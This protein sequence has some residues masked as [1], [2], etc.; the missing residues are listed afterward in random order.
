MNE[1]ISPPLATLNYSEVSNVRLR[2]AEASQIARVA[3]TAFRA[4]LTRGAIFAASVLQRMHGNPVPIEWDP[5]LEDFD[6]ELAERDHEET[7][8]LRAIYK[9][10]TRRR[11]LRQQRH[12]G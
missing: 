9:E 10:I 2:I 6:P 8:K 12:I 5:D 3:A 11:C 4:T 7:E 1:R